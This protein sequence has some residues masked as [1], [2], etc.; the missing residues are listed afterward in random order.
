MKEVI[1]VSN[2]RIAHV[3]EYYRRY[4]HDKI[5]WGVQ[6]TIIRGPRGSG[7]TTLMLQRIKDLEKLGVKALYCTM[8]HPYF[9]TV[10]LYDFAGKVL[11]N[12]FKY[13]FV[14]EIHKHRHWSQD[15]KLIYDTLPEIQIVCSGSSILDIMKGEADLSRRS[16][17]YHL[18]G[19]SFREFLIFQDLSDDPALSLEDI[20]MNHEKIAGNILDDYNVLRHYKKYLQH[21]YFPFFNESIRQYPD[22]LLRV[23]NTTIENDIPAFENIDYSTV[24]SLKKLLYFLSQS[25]PVTPNMIKL[26]GVMGVSRSH[27][28]KM[29]DLMERSDILLLL[30]SP[31]HTPSRMAKPEKIYLHNTNLMSTL[32][33][34]NVNSGSTR[35]TF[36]FNQL[37]V[38]HSVHAPKFGDFMVDQKYVFEIGGPSKNADQIAGIPNA[39]LAL[40]GIKVGAGNRIP[41]WLFGYL[42]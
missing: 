17:V 11:E 13:L 32:S 4:L 2:K 20:L 33:P 35:E 29:M 8:D 31:L 34:A 25:V 28:L 23:I 30:K 36:F 7:K 5:E 27:L 41:L 12:G 22:R 14:D 3:N 9:E 16:A 38:L 42:Y 37:Q 19:L 10:R 6:L 18:P 21:G 1:S 40:D 26:A 15:L 39:Y 24:R